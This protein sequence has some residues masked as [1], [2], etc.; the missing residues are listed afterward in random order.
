VNAFTSAMDPASTAYYGLRTFRLITHFTKLGFMFMSGLVLAMNYYDNHNWPKFLK[1]RFN[2]TI[3]TYLIWTFILFALPLGLGIS[4]FSGNFFLE[5]LGHLLHGDLH[6]MYYLLVTM[7]LYLI[8]PGIVWLFHRFSNGHKQILA[9]SFVLQLLMVTVIK[10]KIW[11]LDTS[12]WLY[13][14]H[15]YSINVITYQ[16]FFIFGTFAS[17]HYNELYHFI[18]QHIRKIV[19]AF[20]ILAIGCFVYYRV[21]NEAILGLGSSHAR[22]SNQ[23]YMVL[24]GTAAILVVFWIGKRYAA[25]RERGMP[26]IVEK[27]FTN[28]AKISFGIYLDQI[29]GLLV[30]QWLLSLTNL[31]DWMLLALLPV[32]WLFVICVSYAIAWF[33]YKVPPL[34]FMI[35]RPQIHFS[36]IRIWIT[37][38][39][40]KK[41]SDSDIE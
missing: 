34:G 40:Q 20:G 6:Y 15:V 4:N 29:I 22:S 9:I 28:G 11:N 5:Y 39:S 38:L 17:Q 10:Y 25:W 32:G 1:K 27:L 31:S 3:W 41:V 13:W 35:G 2:G 7:Q 30:L 19:S 33:F 14:F 16:F 12:N 23:P 26:A 21:L 18:K 8:F 36:D 24:Y 37:N